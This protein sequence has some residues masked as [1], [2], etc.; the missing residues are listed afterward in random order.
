MY[1]SWRNGG[2]HYAITHGR[3]ITI[4]LDLHPTRHPRNRLL[5]G[6]VG[7]MDESV[8]EPISI[9]QH[10]E[11]TPSDLRGRSMRTLTLTK[12]RCELRQRRS[13]PLRPGDRARR[14]LALAG[15]DLSWEARSTSIV[16]GRCMRMRTD[17]FY[18]LLLWRSAETLETGQGYGLLGVYR[19]SVLTE[20]GEVTSGSSCRGPRVVSALTDLA[21][22]EP[23]ERRLSNPA[24]RQWPLPSGTMIRPPSPDECPSVRT[25]SLTSTST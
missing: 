6:Q 14:Q 21:L 12:R 24:A 18:E 8:I 5:P 20:C 23:V 2:G 19:R 4:R 15:H 22:K 17:H 13:R 3:L 25:F 16:F 10:N 1:I 7:D 9:D 11:S